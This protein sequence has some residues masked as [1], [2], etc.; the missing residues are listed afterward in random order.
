VASDHD[1][2]VFVGT[3]GSSG[4]DTI[5]VNAGSGKNVYAFSIHEYSGVTTAVDASSTAQGNSTA[6]AS[7]SLTTV[8]SN[9]L[10]FAWF[11]NGSNYK[12]E[13]FSSLNAAYTKREMSGSSTTQ[14]YGFANCVESGNL[15]ASTTL[16]TNATAT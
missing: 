5:T 6:P 13:N 7:G 10:I 9:D 16:T 1:A 4:A 8:T 2:N 12:N 11:T 14:C 15:V 3:A